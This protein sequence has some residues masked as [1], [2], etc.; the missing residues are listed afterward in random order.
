MSRD[1]RQ[2]FNLSRRLQKI[3]EEQQRKA[4]GA[5][6]FHGSSV[7]AMSFSRGSPLQ[8][9]RCLGRF[10]RR[11]FKLHGLGGDALCSIGRHLQAVARQMAAAKDQCL[12]AAAQCLRAERALLLQRS[13]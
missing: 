5:A 6:R 11:I 3:V 4:V 10:R 1:E 2:L 13:R 9:Q 7:L 8:R 12:I